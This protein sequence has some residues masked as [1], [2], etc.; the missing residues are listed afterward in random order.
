MEMKGREVLGYFFFFE[1]NMREQQ[2]RVDRKRSI[3]ENPGESK[4]T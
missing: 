3:T 1:T 4:K 2:K